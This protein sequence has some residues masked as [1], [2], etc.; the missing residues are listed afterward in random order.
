MEEAMIEFDNLNSLERYKGLIG[1]YNKG[2]LVYPREYYWICFIDF[3][4]GKESHPSIYK[5]S[6]D[7]WE[8][9][10]RMYKKALIGYSHAKKQIG[11]FNNDRTICLKRE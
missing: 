5:G 4:D 6:A 1:I 9:A 7:S 2:R 11:I 3:I 8:E 10:L